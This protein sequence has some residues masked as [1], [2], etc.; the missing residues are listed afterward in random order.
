MSPVSHNFAAR[1][2]GAWPWRKFAKYAKV[3]LLCQPERDLSFFLFS[4][5]YFAKINWNSSFLNRF[6]CQ[7][8][9]RG[10]RKKLLK[11]DIIAK[12]NQTCLLRQKIEAFRRFF[13]DTEAGDSFRFRCTFAMT[14][15]YDFKA[16]RSRDWMRES[17]FS[18]SKSKLSFAW[19]WGFLIKL[20]MSKECTTNG[21]FIS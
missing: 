21:C 19:T 1:E 11:W 5:L 16:I 20:R 14:E 18:F 13:G 9:F 7:N 17:L 2:K 4:F 15:K 10:K 8:T 3:Q 6:F 12:L